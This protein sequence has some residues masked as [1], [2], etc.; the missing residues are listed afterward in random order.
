MGRDR[1]QTSANAEK[2]FDSDRLAPIRG[3]IFLNRRIASAAY[4]GTTSVSSSQK[5]MFRAQAGAEMQ[6]N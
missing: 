1:S 2:A 5:E 4:I 6:R 3:R